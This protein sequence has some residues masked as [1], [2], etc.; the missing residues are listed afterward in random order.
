MDILKTEKG[1][2]KIILQYTLA[3]ECIDLTEDCI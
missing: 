1:G 3:C 2:N